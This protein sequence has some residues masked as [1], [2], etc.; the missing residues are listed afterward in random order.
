MIESVDWEAIAAKLEWH[1]VDE[2][3]AAWDDVLACEYHTGEEI[4]LD[5]TPKKKVR[6]YDYESEEE[7]GKEEEADVEEERRQ[8]GPV[9]R[10]DM[11]DV[12]PKVEEAEEEERQESPERACDLFEQL[13]E[14]LRRGYA[15]MAAT[16]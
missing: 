4:K 12:K 13:K 3:R 15:E 6:R 11:E 10:E 8:E 2:F 14:E 1:T 9:H 16:A 5:P 7:E